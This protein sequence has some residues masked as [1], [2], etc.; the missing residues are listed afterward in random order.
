LTGERGVRLDFVSVHEKGAWPFLWDVLS[1]NT[2]R[3]V[4][5]EARV[6]DYV[7]AHHPSLAHLAF[8][9]N[10]CDPQLGWW[11]NH[12]WRATPYY[13]ALVCKV[14]NQHL[15]RFIDGM[16]CTYALLGNDNGFLG[17]W[18]Q[19][20]LLARFGDMADVRGQFRHHRHS[21]D[22]HEDRT[23]RRF[24]LIK[25]PVFSAMVMLALLGDTRCAV[26]GCGDPYADVGVIATRR[27]DG[28]VAILV[29]NSRDRVHASAVQEIELQ[30]RGLPLARSMLAH[31]CI[32][33]EHT[34][35]Y[36]MWQSMGEPDQP[37]PAQYARLRDHQ[38]LA[39]LEE[40]R[41]VEATGGVLTLRFALPLPGISLILL[42]DRPKQPPGKVEGL[43]VELY[44]GLTGKEE[45][46]L[47]WQDVES[48][49][50]RTYEV[51]CAPS[52]DGPFKRV[53]EAD[54]L[55]TAFLHVREASRREGYYRVCAVDLWGRRGDMSET[56]A[57]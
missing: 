6:I 10:E 25:K 48:R 57:V 44:E 32:D 40:L 56:L 29:Y 3:I 31:Y 22:L 16:G 49:A 47:V 51:C 34:N 53:N 13:A 26:D 36:A 8:M 15:L 5:R 41:E 27:G 7:R 28:Q 11:H 23:R 33:Q 42:S 21:I 1:P 39:L 45:V 24:E 19:R 38:E 54:L 17:G 14:V 4:D 12:D 50:I 43:R 46:M 30:L 9:N 35:P 2:K 18:G 37:S 52:P 20:T 55:C